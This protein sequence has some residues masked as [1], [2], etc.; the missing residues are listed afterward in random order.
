MFQAESAP[1]PRTRS[2]LVCTAQEPA[3][4]AAPS[5]G[6][7]APPLLEQEPHTTVATAPGSAGQ[8]GT[9]GA[10]R[11]LLADANHP[12]C[13]LPHCGL[14]GTHENRSFQTS[15]PRHLPRPLFRSTCATQHCCTHLP[16][17][18]AAVTRRRVPHEVPPLLPESYNVLRVKD[19]VRKGERAERGQ[20]WVQ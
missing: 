14:Q 7:C 15:S 19:P 20:P 8:Q 5:C 10:L 1:A 6:S 2:S 4:T 11:L 18:G 17:V 12:L 13:P 16:H 9:A 3:S